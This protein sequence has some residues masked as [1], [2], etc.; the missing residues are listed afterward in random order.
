MRA[1]LALLTLVACPSIC[2]SGSR[3]VLEAPHVG[4]RALH[5]AP[6]P[7]DR[8]WHTPSPSLG[9]ACE[10]MIA[11]GGLSFAAMLLNGASHSGAASGNLQR[12]AACGLR[13]EHRALPSRSGTFAEGW[14]P[15][16][17]N[18]LS[19]TAMVQGCGRGCI[20]R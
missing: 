7:A 4:W 9:S 14:D 3:A 13:P 5:P 19:G 18:V 12:S 17:R 15:F 16:P 11:R 8:P 2:E 6:R 1:L 10:A 20:G